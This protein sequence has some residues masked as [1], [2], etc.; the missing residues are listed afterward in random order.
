MELSGYRMKVEKVCGGNYGVYTSIGRFS[1]VKSNGV[2][3]VIMN[4][5]GKIAAEA[6]KKKA[7]GEIRQALI[8]HFS[9]GRIR[10]IP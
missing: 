4:G 6:T 3:H 7:I 8:D 10:L 5:F 9:G 2:W 1:V